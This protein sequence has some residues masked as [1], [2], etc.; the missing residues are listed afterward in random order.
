MNGRSENYHEI[1]P[2]DHQPAFYSHPN[3]S[4]MHLI[5]PLLF[6]HQAFMHQLMFPPSWIP[7][8]PLHYTLPKHIPEAMNNNY[9]LTNNENHDRDEM[10][11]SS[12]SSYSGS[13]SP[14]SQMDDSVEIRKCIN[15]K[16]PKK[17]KTFECK[18]CDKVFGYKHVLQN[19]E[20]VHTGEKSYQCTRCNRRFR[21]DH[22]L[23][24]HIRVHT[25]EKPFSCDFPMCD[26]KFT[27]VANL[28]RHKKIHEHVNLLKNH[29]KMLKSD[30]KFFT[31][32][33]REESE[34]LLKHQNSY[35]YEN[36]VQ[37]EPEDLSTKTCTLSV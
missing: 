19:H 37:S 12:N 35:I 17:N 14:T 25:G 9:L 7:W 16:D 28:R 4:A 11:L 23:K 10:K 29:Q 15:K 24:V 21:R 3:A 32:E 20:K 18:Y 5:D 30:E 1:S 36:S 33:S 6:A 31:S 8:S 27:Q 13:D 22:H 2:K 26:Q 34:E